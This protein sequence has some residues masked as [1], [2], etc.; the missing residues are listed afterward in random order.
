MLFAL[1][2]PAAKIARTLALAALIGL[3]LVSCGGGSGG[4]SV[5]A[6]T[7][8]TP[9]APVTPTVPETPVSSDGLPIIQLQAGTV[10]ISAEVANTAAQREKGLMY[11]TE[12][13][14]NNGMLFE[15]SQPVGI[16]MWML[17]TTIP[18]SVAFME[19]DGTIVNIEDMQPLTYEEHCGARQLRFA[20]EMNQ[21][22]F[23]LNNIKPGDKIT[24]LPD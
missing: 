14:Q 24:G 21:G 5:P 19:D 3:G 9:T 16:C 11:R 13:G 12:L 18:L 22:W 6:T 15:F 2:C 10:T 7:E 8:P 17:N 23:A 1:Q 4:D 20:L